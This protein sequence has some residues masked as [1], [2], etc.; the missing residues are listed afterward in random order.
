MTF[1]AF[2][3]GAL[4]LAVALL[5]AVPAHAA[6]V[7]AA[8]ER[9]PTFNGVVWATAYDGDTVYVGG[10]FGAVNGVSGSARLAAVHPA[11]GAVD[12]SFRS[13]AVDEVRALAV[14]GSTVYA[15]H[16]GP[17]GPGG[18]VVAYAPDGSGRWNLTMDGDP[19]AITVLDDVVYF[20]GH[21]DN[22]CRSPRTGT[23]G[24]C[25]DGSIKRVK[26]GAAAT[27][28]GGLLSWTANGNG[29]AGVH[30]LAASG[31]LAKVGAGGAFTKIN[32]SAQPYFAQFS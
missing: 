5:P 32:G 14:S 1:R 16:G 25:L 18:R 28:D 8:P 23:K 21:F 29:S 13:T 7:S 30:A 9:T 17:G 12:L 10:K 22:V 11:S 24:S 20:G 15:A 31:R 6:A 3:F 2:R 4:G 19:Q 27:G 26:L